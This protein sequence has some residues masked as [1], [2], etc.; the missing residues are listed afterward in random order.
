[1]PPN[2]LSELVGRGGVVRWPH[3]LQGQR[4][5]AGGPGQVWLFVSLASSSPR[6]APPGPS[7]SLA[8]CPLLVQIIGLDNSDGFIPQDV[9]LNIR[10]SEAAAFAISCC[11]RGNKRGV[12]VI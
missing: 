10:M 11:Q 7:R 2:I 1:M 5:V 9:T 8:A 12:A 4:P 3:L 6:P